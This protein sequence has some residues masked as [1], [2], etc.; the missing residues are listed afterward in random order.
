MLDYAQARRMMVDCQLRPFDVHDLRV[1]AAFDAVPRELFVP[2]E[3]QSLA[4]S[5]QDIPA[6]MGEGETRCLLKPMVLARLVQALDIK[7]GDRVLDVAGGR[8]YSAAVLARL[9]ASVVALEATQSLAETARACLAKAGVAG[10]EVVAGPLQAGH[11]AGG[12]Y[13]AILVNG[14][15][16]ERPETLLHQL[17]ENG[18]LVCVR[19]RG[20]AGKATLFVR[21]GDAFGAWPLF[22]AAAPLLAAFKV[23][24]GFVF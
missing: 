6:G 2:D 9:G 4:Y 5:D 7:A 1:L 11:A 14:A 19:G 23:E 15:V 21:S 8:G 3:W 24:P 22:D 12:P 20:R 13:D 18:R 16:D 17:R 10:A